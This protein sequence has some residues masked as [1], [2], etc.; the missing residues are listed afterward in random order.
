MNIIIQGLPEMVEINGVKY[1]ISCD[2]RTGMKFDEILDSDISDVQK[3]LRTLRLYYPK[4]IPTDIHAA[5]DKVIWFYRCG[6]EEPKKEERE[7]Y[8]RRNSKE[9]AYSFTQDAPYIYAAF[10]EQYGIDLMTEEKL[11]WWKFMALF[12]SLSEDTKMAQIMYFRKANVSGMSRDRRAYVNEMKKLYKLNQ[13]KKLT[14][15]ERNAKW[16]EHIRMRY[17]EEAK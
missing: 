8:K 5:I 2:F 14:L 12:E 4:K 1:P 15:E 17:E 11:H 10:K 7:R 6:K 3:L 9:P 13:G 16:K